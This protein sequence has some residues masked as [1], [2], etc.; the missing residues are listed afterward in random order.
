[1]LTFAPGLKSH[2]TATPAKHPAQQ[3][4]RRHTPNILPFTFSQIPLHSPAKYDSAVEAPP[5]AT[6]ETPA[7]TVSS[8]N[9]TPAQ[10]GTVP[11]VITPPGKGK[12]TGGGPEEPAEDKPPLK[13]VDAFPVVA[14][15]TLNPNP[16]APA[17]Q[18]GNKT[19]PVVSAITQG[20]LSQPPGKPVSPFGAESF[21]PTFT[22]ISYAFAGG[23]CN[24]TGT[25]NPICPWGTASGGDTDVPSATDPV[26]TKDN[27][28]A[29]K[30]DLAPGASSPFK[31]PRSTYYSQSLVERHEKFHGT[32]DNGWVTSSGLAIIK[33]SLES[34]NVSNGLLTAA[35]E[36]AAVVEIARLK[37]IEENLKW[38]KGT[39][40]AHDSYAGEIR[41]Y[42]DGKPEYQ[43]LADAVEVQG[44]KLATP[45]PPP[46]APVGGVT[47]PS[48][49]P[50]PV[51]HH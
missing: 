21:E 9:T 15:I 49:P 6:Q 12:E 11:D 48:P 42:A 47:A 29:I 43:K 41:A 19:D 28:P 2:Q 34:R 31:S 16:P 33:A 38:Y 1:M 3:P 7:P 22:G 36:V 25:F 13:A 24:I 32:D 18:S 40:T 27:W 10:S 14:R 45:P 26:V 51:P 5:E 50:P 46:T 35:V 8:P 39:G 37:A 17:L 23:K 4:P 20:A 30:A 44:R